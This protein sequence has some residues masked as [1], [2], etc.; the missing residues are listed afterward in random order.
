MVNVNIEIPPELHKRLK[1]A[2]AT[3]DMTLK[4][5]VITLLAGDVPQTPAT[6]PSHT[7]HHSDNGAN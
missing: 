5:L 7:H 6:Q 2:A 4:D 3:D 1:V